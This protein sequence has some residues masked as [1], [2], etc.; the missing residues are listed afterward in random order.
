MQWN[1]AEFWFERL[2]HYYF[3]D[4]SD[5][6][7]TLLETWGNDTRAQV[8]R[9]V[10]T[11]AEKDPKWQEYGLHLLKCFSVCKENRNLIVH[12]L[13]K[14][15]TDN[16]LIVERATRR[17]SSRAS[18]KITLKTLK[19][20]EWEILMLCSHLRFFESNT[21]GA[22]PNLEMRAPL[23]DRLPLPRKLAETHRAASVAR[24]SEATSGAN[25]AA[26][27]PHFAPLMPGYKLI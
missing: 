18:Y 19:Q 23:P 22:L 27:D 6:L 20:T 25:L 26:S 12:G 16:Y 4:V 5:Y 11:H 21:S 9:G 14:R 13:I 24:M 7:P 2:F 17:L 3:F 1:V 15:I 8:L 10:I